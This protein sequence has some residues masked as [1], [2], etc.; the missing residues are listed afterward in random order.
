MAVADAARTADTARRHG[1]DV[2]VVA[3][4]DPLLHGIG[5]TLIRLFGADRVTVLP[6]VS[7]VTLACAR[8][9]WAVQDTEVIS[10]VT[11]E[12]HTAVR[13]G[14]QAVVLS[15]RRRRSRRAGPAAHRH[16]PRRL[17]THRARAARRAG[18][19]APRRHRARVGGRPP[20][21][22]DD[23]NV[24]AVR[25]LPDDRMSRAARRRV[26]P[27]RPDHQAVDAGGHAGGA[28]AAAGRAAVG[29]RL[30]IGQHRDRMVPQ[31][32]RL[33]R[34]WH[35]N[36]TSSAASG[37][38]RTPSAFGADVDVRG[39]APEA[40]DDAVLTSGVDGVPRRR[41][42]SSAAA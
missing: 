38:P 14:G 29:R 16:R 2:H 24:V 23:L 22:V 39:D 36:A 5:D 28:G 37:S 32:I 12:P 1:G 41:R 33:S 7:S 31:R 34:Q 3:S 6:H 30:R 9:G 10:L 20:G 19:A 11:A 13:R 15:P 42:S 35:S 40:F 17:R 4:G 27:R 8:L 25:Y 21:D 18:R 26:R